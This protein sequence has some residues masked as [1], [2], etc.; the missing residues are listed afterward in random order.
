MPDEGSAILFNGKGEKL[1]HKKY[2]VV[3]DLKEGEVLVEITLATV[4]GSDVHTWLGHRPFPTP[5]ILGHE[6]VG[7]IL[8]LGDSIKEDFHGEPLK[9]GDRIVWSMTVGCKQDDCFFCMNNLPQKCIRLFKYGHEKSDV[10]PHFSG[11][12][13]KYIIL[14]KNSDIF[15]IHDRLKDAEVAPLM[16]AGACVLNGLQLAKFSKCKYLIVQGC[17]A[18]GL[19]ACAFG[20]KLGAEKV[21]A[22]DK[23]ESRLDIAKQ[24]GADYTIVLKNRE[25]CIQKIN[26]ITE[27]RGADYVVEVS[28]DPFAIELGIDM[29]RIGGKYVLL[30]AIYPDSNFT[31]DSSKVIRNSIQLIGLHN[32]G[33]E[34]LGMALKL[35]LDT[36]T[37][38]PYEKMVGPVFDFNGE[39]VEKAFHA[40]DTKKSIRP[41]IIPE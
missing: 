29:I 21:I 36:K 40:L 35:V 18:L 38:Y 10:E 8:K 34:N 31:I 20:K 26:E 37:E 24:F 17:G 32:Y 14:K 28:G 5:C 27:S 25:E 15:K 23:T 30:G 6:M 3:E 41:A 4:C 11:G 22:I 7:K 12:F 9:I 16:C 33:P 1:E 2:P 19:Y 13:A 39:G